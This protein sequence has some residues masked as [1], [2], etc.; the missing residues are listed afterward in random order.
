MLGCLDSWNYDI[1][2]IIVFIE[3]YLA[4]QKMIPIDGGL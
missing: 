1:I 3:I 2:S 4:Q